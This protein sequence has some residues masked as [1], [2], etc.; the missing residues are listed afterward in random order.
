MAEGEEGQ[1]VNTHR[2]HPARLCA[3]KDAYWAVVVAEAPVPTTSHPKL[4]LYREDPG[5]VA[6]EEQV[7]NQHPVP[8]PYN[9]GSSQ[10]RVETSTV[11]DR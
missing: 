11:K 8:A 3:E 9:R 7:P 4:L 2:S 10:G 5:R 1:L 6:T